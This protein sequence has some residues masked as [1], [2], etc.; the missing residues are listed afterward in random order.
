MLGPNAEEMTARARADLR[1]GTPVAVVSDNVGGIAVS[2]EM[3]STDRL[4]ALRA[5]SDTLD[6]VITARRA[7]TL[8]AR[9]YD[10]DIARISF[11]YCIDP[12]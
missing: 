2:S 6:L 12:V 1:I 7:E 3:I 9:A 10:G 5:I 8:Q 4:G 11:T